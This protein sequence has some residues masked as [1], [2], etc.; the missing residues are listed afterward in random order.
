MRKVK[1][2]VLFAIL[3]IPCIVFAQADWAKLNYYAQEREM[4]VLGIK[5]IYLDEGEGRVILLVHGFTGNA[6]NWMDVFEPLVKDFR[7]IVP[8]LPGYG[9]SACPPKEQKH[10]MLWYA[11]FLSQFLEKLDVEKAVV[12]GNSMGGAVAGW[13]AVRHPEKVEALVLVDSA[14]LNMPKIR[15]LTFLGA[16]TFGREMVKLIE[17]ISPHSEKALSKL[18]KSEQKRAILADRR[19]KSELREC[20]SIT[21]KRC[22]V[23]LGN[24]LLTEELA[25]IQAPTL[26]IWGDDDAVIS[27]KNAERFAKRIPNAKVKIIKNGDH[28][29]MQHKPEEFVRVLVDFI[30]SVV[31]E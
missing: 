1:K 11:D 27:V 15:F 8:D 18:P 5:T 23:S 7:V 22:V 25:K 28:T 12:V 2:T 26:I 16:M 31:P 17:A 24:D 10:L 30:K 6:F 3:L 21:M 9:K 4:E 13:L 29:P 14:G 20:S 19:Y